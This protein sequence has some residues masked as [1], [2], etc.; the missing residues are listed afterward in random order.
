MQHVQQAHWNVFVCPFGCKDAQVDDIPALKAHLA[1]FHNEHAESLSP[2]S[3]I[4]SSEQERPLDAPK[5]CELCSEELDSFK[6]YTRHVGRHQ[7]DVALFVL[8]NRGIDEESLSDDQNE[9]LGRHDDKVSDGL[10]RVIWDEAVIRHGGDKLPPL[11][12][13]LGWDYRDAVP[14]PPQ[15]SQGP[16]PKPPPYAPESERLQVEREP[17][18]TFKYRRPDG[19]VEDGPEQ[20]VP[21]TFASSHQTH[22]P[23]HDNALQDGSGPKDRS[24]ASLTATQPPNREDMQSDPRHSGIVVGPGLV[25]YPAP[26]VSIK[27]SEGRIKLAPF[28]NTVQESTG[29]REESLVD[30]PEYNPDAHLRPEIT[31]RPPS[32][33]AQDEPGGDE[34]ESLVLDNP[35]NVPEKYL[36]PG[37]I[38]QSSYT[39]AQDEPGIAA[40]HES[41]AIK[42]AQEGDK[43]RGGDGL[44][45]DKGENWESRYPASTMGIR[46]NIRRV[47]PGLPATQPIIKRAQEE[48]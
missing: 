14:P 47:V 31:H 42:R 26:D 1:T 34:W 22:G 38:P 17:L 43:N 44:N 16:L 9:E 36:D 19:S 15:P 21:V 48:D 4:R 25:F 13:A 10:S 29:L 24:S 11:V 41:N 2:E 30:N 37:I 45:L 32:A 27:D 8:P 33:N 23:H 18:C 28:W 46:R 35:G 20:N 3:L 7:E 5:Q 6:A 39:D 40:H 12:E